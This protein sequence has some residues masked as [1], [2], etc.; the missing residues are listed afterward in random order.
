MS[1]ESTGAAGTGAALIE[2]LG[3]VDNTFAGTLKVAAQGDHPGQGYRF[4]K[5][6]GVV[7]SNRMELLNGAVVTLLNSP[8]IGDNATVVIKEGSRL[9]LNGFNETIGNLV[10]TNSASDTSA[11]LV[12]TEGGTL[13]VLGSLTSGNANAAVVPTVK[14]RLA[15]PTAGEHFDIGGS[16]YAGLDV[17][18]QITGAGGFAKFGDA[19]LLLRTNNTFAGSVSVNEGIVEARHALAFGGTTRGVTVTDGS[20]TLNNVLVSGETLF[21]RGTRDVTANTAGSL[22]TGLGASSGWLGRIELD[23]NLVVNSQDLCVLGGPI[24]GSGGLE[25]LGSRNQIVGSGSTQSTYTGL[26]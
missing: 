11:S 12:D 5:T 26:T 2:F 8:L 16:V 1:A 20:I 25:F 4:S 15:L 18:G 23:T 22:L 13:T 24:V 7:V 21:V 3:A 9:R 14:G 10:L 6:S 17:Q 19:A